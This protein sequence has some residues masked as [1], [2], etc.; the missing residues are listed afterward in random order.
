MNRIADVC[1]VLGKATATPNAF[2]L[3]QSF[4]ESTDIHRRKKYAPWIQLTSWAKRNRS[5]LTTSCA[6]LFGSGE[7]IRR[8]LTRIYIGGVSDSVKLFRQLSVKFL[9][10]SFMQKLSG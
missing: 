8:C 5:L 4:R 6:L 1:F 3:F 10:N 2:S 9:I 7:R